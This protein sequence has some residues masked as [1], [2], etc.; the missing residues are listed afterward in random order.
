D[1]VAGSGAPGD[2]GGHLQ[3][4][5]LE[6]GEVVTRD[7]RPGDSADAQEHRNDGDECYETDAAPSR[8]GLGHSIILSGAGREG[9][10]PTDRAP[11]W[12]AGARS[13]VR[14]VRVR[15]PGAGARSRRRWSAR[16]PRRRRLRPPATR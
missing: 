6:R 1:Q 9:W 16:W 15:R 14:I 10:H 2:I 11:A 12:V 13:E 5:G 3:G 8:S 4:A 7:A